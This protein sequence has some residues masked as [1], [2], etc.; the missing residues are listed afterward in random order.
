MSSEV[1]DAFLVVELQDL[2]VCKEATA[3]GKDIQIKERCKDRWS[4]L[5]RAPS[6]K[7]LTCVE[8]V[9]PVGCL[10]TTTGLHLFVRHGNRKSRRLGQA[11]AWNWVKVGLAA[12]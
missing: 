10:T 2:C 4:W 3:R 6:V 12:E 8:P 5:A 11:E 1:V 7:W 9:N